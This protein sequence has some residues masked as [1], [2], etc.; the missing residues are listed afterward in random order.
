MV[1]FRSL[2][3]LPPPPPPKHLSEEG[4]EALSGSS[5]SWCER[6][7][8]PLVALCYRDGVLDMAG[9][10]QE[11]GAFL[12]IL[13]NAVLLKGATRQIKDT[14]EVVVYGHVA[15]TP[16]LDPR[17]ALLLEGREAASVCS[18][19]T[20]YSSVTSKVRGGRR[21]WW[22][23]DQGFKTPQYGIDLPADGIREVWSFYQERPPGLYPL[24]GL[25]FWLDLPLSLVSLVDSRSE[26]LDTYFLPLD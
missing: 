24:E 22:L 12:D 2:Y 13:P 26:I 18:D 1:A 9:V 15:P 17:T 7:S 21:F 6:V 14:S 20:L 25:V 11:S 23:Q 16:H 10:R 8:G 3:D 4:L 5:I 19:L